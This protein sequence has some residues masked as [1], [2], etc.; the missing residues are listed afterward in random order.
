MSPIVKKKKEKFKLPSKYVLLILTA[1][2]IVLMAVTFMTN[3]MGGP[4]NTVA[5]YIVVPFQEGISEI[6]GFLTQKSDELLELRDVLAENEELRQQVADLTSENIQ[7]Q[8]QQYELE[9]LQ[10]LFELDAGY[11]DYEKTGARIISKDSG[12]WYSAFVIN[13]GSADGL[14]VDMNVIAGAGLVGRITQIGENWARV[15]SI[16]DDTMNVSSKVLSTNDNIIV[17]GNLA[18][19]MSGKIEFSQLLDNDNE[20]SVGDKIVTSDISD[21]YL[22]GI[23][24]GYITDLQVDANNLSK[25]GLLT[26]AVDFEHLSEVLV[27]LEKKQ[28][29]S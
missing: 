26:P 5:G 18:L 2:C 20:V 24:I 23:L 1:L 19:M 27:I 6:G 9:N 8:Q 21:K 29:V 16:I 25:S 15:T 4:L 12:N 22:P 7:L 14:E 13:K 10:T 17:S 11:V 28:E 3:Y